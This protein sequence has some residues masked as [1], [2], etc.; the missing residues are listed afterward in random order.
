MM[1]TDPTPSTALPTLGDPAP[2]RPLPRATIVPPPPPPPAG[3]PPGALASLIYG[4][5]SILCCGMPVAGL[6]LGIAAIVC[7][8]RARSAVQAAPMR[9]L[10][11]GLAT[12][13]LVT[14]II[15][16]VLSTL[17]IL[18]WTTLLLLLLAIL[19]AVGSALGG[20]TAAVTVPGPLL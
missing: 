14:G 13:G 19:G 9:Y 15:G 18:F 20:H 3:T 4:V 7:A 1:T 16:T 10:P 12:G 5:L 11:S 17:V 6:I 8:G 2:A